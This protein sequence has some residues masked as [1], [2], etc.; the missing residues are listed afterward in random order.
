MSE[1][2][3]NFRHLACKC[4]V[5]KRLSRGNI[6][7]SVQT[8]LY[9]NRKSMYFLKQILLVI[10]LCHSSIYIIISSTLVYNLNHNLHFPFKSSFKFQLN[11]G[12]SIYLLQFL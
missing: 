11:Q 6:K 4:P 3:L 12:S 7:V 5:Y 1:R 10:T 9:V 8:Y 2:T